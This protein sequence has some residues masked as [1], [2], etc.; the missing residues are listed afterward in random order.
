[1]V[2]IIF[3]KFVSVIV[4][5]SKTKEL[6]IDS[7]L[8]VDAVEVVKLKNL[9]SD[10]INIVNIEYDVKYGFKDYV[11]EYNGG[12]FWLTISEL[13]GYFKIIDGVGYLESLLSYQ[14]EAMYDEVWKKVA[15]DA[16]RSEAFVKDT[17]KF[18]LYSDDLPKDH[19]FVINKITIVI[20]SVV[21]WKSVFYPQ[22]SLNYCSCDV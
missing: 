22:I 21:E 1:M 4:N 8:W 17:K 14:Q 15:N 20:K 18:I 19:E 6:S 9:V 3:H 11:I 13:K 5:M 12:G 7:T 10:K 16:G 2:L